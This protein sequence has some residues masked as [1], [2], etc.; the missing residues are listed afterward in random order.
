MESLKASEKKTRAKVED[1]FIDVYDE[2]PWHL[3]EQMEEL[4]NHISKNRDK[5]DLTAYEPSPMTKA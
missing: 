3:K 4:K 5:Y 2:M 1:L